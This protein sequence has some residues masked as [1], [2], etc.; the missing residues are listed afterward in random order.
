MLL[1]RITCGCRPILT[2]VR[3][4]CAE[5]TSSLSRFLQLRGCGTS[6]S[7]A[8]NRSRRTRWRTRPNRYGRMAWTKESPRHRA[9]LRPRRMGTKWMQAVPQK[10]RRRTMCYDPAAELAPRNQRRAECQLKVVG[11]GWLARPAMNSRHRTHLIVSVSDLVRVH[12]VSSLVSGQDPGKPPRTSS[13]LLTV[14]LDC[15]GG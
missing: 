8:S 5:R 13:Y 7:A 1:E 12:Q 3:P 10:R 4:E 11:V 6:T 9:P 14:K 2:V 15:R